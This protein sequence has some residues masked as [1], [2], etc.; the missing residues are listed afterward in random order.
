MLPCDLSDETAVSE[1]LKDHGKVLADVN[2]VFLNAGI[3]Q[4][5][6]AKD[7][8]MSVVRKVMDVNF[9]GTVQL[10][11][12]IVSYI[13]S[14]EGKIIVISSVAGKFGVPFRSTYCASKHALHGYFEAVRIEEDVDVLL[15]CP[16]FIETDISKNAVTGTGAIYGEMDNGQANGMPVD[17]AVSKI[18]EA[19]RKGKKEIFIGGFR[20]TKLAV[21]MHKNF[22][23]IFFKILRKTK[24]K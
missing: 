8:E 4:R 1:M 20:E 10:S 22:P 12:F 3:S 7:T 24:V 9:F 5:S 14:N 21:F 2:F 18:L 17:K 13:K 6:L 16:G 23:S 11:Q 15:V 19:T